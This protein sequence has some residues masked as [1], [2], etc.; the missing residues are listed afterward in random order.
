MKEEELRKMQKAG[1]KMLVLK[2]I[3]E[4]ERP[5]WE[6]DGCVEFYDGLEFL[7][8]PSLFDV[9]VIEMEEEGVRRFAEEL[10]KKKKNIGIYK[11]GGGRK[12]EGGGKK[13]G[14]G[15]RKEEGGGRKE[16]GGGGVWEE[17]EEGVGLE[18]IRRR[19]EAGRKKR[20]EEEAQRLER[21]EK[22]PVK[23]KKMRFRENITY[24]AADDND[25]ILMG[26]SHL[27]LEKPAKV[28][29]KVFCK[30]MTR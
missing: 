20:E 15:G 29:K 13:E 8:E 11:I 21:L 14:G 16:G 17:V 26:I 3:W 12:E 25:F 10:R 4:G 6:E 30:N 18:E 19:W 2:K 1:I 27:K 24:L 7:P 9:V 5:E 28:L 23:E 22:S